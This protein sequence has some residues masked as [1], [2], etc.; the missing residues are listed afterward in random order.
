MCSAHA[1]TAPIQSSQFLDMLSRLQS[2]LAVG[3]IADERTMA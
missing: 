3:P 2:L 1:Y